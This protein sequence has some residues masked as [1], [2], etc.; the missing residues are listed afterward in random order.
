[1]RACG[2]ACVCVCVYARASVRPCVRASVSTLSGKRLRTHVHA[3]ATTESQHSHHQSAFA[4]YEKKDG[5]LRRCHR[6]R[7]V[8]ALVVLPLANRP[9]PCCLTSSCHG[10][11]THPLAA[12]YESSHRD[13]CDCDPHCQ[14]QPSH[15]TAQNNMLRWHSQRQTRLLSPLGQLTVQ[16]YVPCTCLSRPAPGESCH[17]HCCFQRPAPQTVCSPSV[18]DLY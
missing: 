9:Q 16:R 6:Q 8:R 7:S 5:R 17:A 4:V 15:C 18:N 14:R 13:L 2:R 1:V 3:T 10:G 11:G 12:D